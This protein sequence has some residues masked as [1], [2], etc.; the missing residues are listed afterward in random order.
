[1]IDVNKG[2]LTLRVGDE[3]VDFNLD[4]NLKQPEFYNTECKTIETIIPISYELKCDCKIQ[5]SITENEMNFQ[6]IEDLDVEFLN[7]SFE[8]KQ[9]ILNLNEESA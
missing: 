7:S 2:E 8:F 5:S 1:M 3:T 4:H 9:T 6:Y